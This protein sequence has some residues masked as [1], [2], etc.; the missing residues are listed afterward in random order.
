MISKTTKNEYFGMLGD[1]ETEKIE[2]KYAPGEKEL[3]NVLAVKGRPGR[4]RHVRPDPVKTEPKLE[5]EKDQ[6]RLASVSNENS[7][8]SDLDPIQIKSELV[9]NA[10]KCIPVETPV[11]YLVGSR[12][13]HEGDTGTVSVELHYSQAVTENSDIK[14]KH[15]YYLETEN[16]ENGLIIRNG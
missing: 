14:R 1:Y 6:C 8:C 11:G 16:K 9:E 3:L 12:K 7:F 5:Y 13:D 4:K 15:S 10:R 2:L